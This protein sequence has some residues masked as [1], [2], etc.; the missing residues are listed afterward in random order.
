VSRAGPAIALL[1]LMLASA[2]ADADARCVEPAK[3]MTVEE[4]VQTLRRSADF[5]GMVEIVRLEATAS[6]RGAVVRAIESIK[7][8]V[9]MN[10]EMR[11]SKVMPD[12]SILVVSTESNRIAGPVDSRHVVALQ[13]GEA[14]WYRNLCVEQYL[15]LPGVREEVERRLARRGKHR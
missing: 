10:L 9:N 4:A 15:D 11:P 8:P 13:K 7:G 3:N 5:L 6:H 12:D 1:A 14:G 2:T